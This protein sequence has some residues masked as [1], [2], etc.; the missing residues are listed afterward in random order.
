MAILTNPRHERF[1]Q[2]LAKGKTADE[3][4]QL[5][6]YA[7][8]RCNASRLKANENILARVAELQQRGAER[9]A[10]TVESLI[11][12][13][14]AIQEAAL[15]D[16]QYGPAVSALTAKAKLAGHWV[17]RKEDVTVRRHLEQIDADIARLVAAGIQDGTIEVIGGASADGS[18]DQA[19]PTVPGHGTA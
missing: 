17:E 3:A 14:G 6:G 19:I 16:G 18:G 1:A 5:A 7:E 9:A 2:E 10:V 11:E 8:N 13:A 4:Y 15:H 12:E